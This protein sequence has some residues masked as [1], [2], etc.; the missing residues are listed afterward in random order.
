MANLFDLGH[1]W[2]VRKQAQKF[3]VEV[4]F[5]GM[6][7]KQDC[8]LALA[9]LAKAKLLPV[10]FVMVDGIE[11]DDESTITLFGEASL[12]LTYY[13]MD[14]AKDLQ[15]IKA[16]L[17]DFETDTDYA[18]N[19]WV[20]DYD[21]YGKIQIRSRFESENWTDWAYWDEELNTEAA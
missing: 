10:Q 1:V 17:Y 2:N 13:S 9:K 4:F 18:E 7:G 5:R 16:V 6:G 15:S 19:S 3:E 21:Q 12:G 8:V 11:F 20:N 14:P